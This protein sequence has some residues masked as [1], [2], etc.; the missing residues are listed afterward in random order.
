MDVPEADPDS[1]PEYQSMYAIDCEMV[2][3][4]RCIHRIVY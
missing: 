4:L 1:K 3:G 2:R